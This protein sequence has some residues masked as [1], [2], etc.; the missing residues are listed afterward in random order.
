MMLGQEVP[1]KEFFGWKAL[2]CL[3]LLF[4]FAAFLSW[5]VAEDP[6]TNMAVLPSASSAI[7]PPMQATPKAWQLP[8]AQKL[9]ARLPVQ[10]Q[11]FK[12][13]VEPETNGESRRDMFAK[14]AGWGLA[15][16]A[17]QNQAAQAKDFGTM[18]SDNE[19][20]TVPSA[21]V[22]DY[23]QDIK[24]PQGKEGWTGL[25]PLALAPP[26]VAATWALTQILGPATEQL[27]GMNEKAGIAKQ[28]L[29]YRAPVDPNLAKRRR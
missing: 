24:P 15:A 9:R 8:H 20:Y 25:P 28:N 19:Y 1:R 11:A 21:K 27:D 22:S 13:P 3:S 12:S 26:L 2:L 4:G 6:A 7:K 29:F 16:A 17:A 10:T 18:R 5:P 23:Q 14:A